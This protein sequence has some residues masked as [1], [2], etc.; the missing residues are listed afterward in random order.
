MNN[1]K[2]DA[3]RLAA[4]QMNGDVLALRI[5]DRAREAAFSRGETRTRRPSA[6]QMARELEQGQGEEGI[7]DEPVSP[8]PGWGDVGSGPR[9]SRRD[10]HPISD[11]LERTIRDKGWGTQL[12]VAAVL[13]RW[14]EI[15]G[16][17]I[18]KHCVV[19]SFDDDG[20]LTLRTSSTSWEA[21]INA[22]LATLE[23]RVVEEVGEGIVK[24]IMVIG[25]NRP[26]WKHGRLSVPGRGPRDTYD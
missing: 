6:G 17:T 8:G 13:A 18:A 12:K 4:A 7:G 16:P 26:S 14:P 19:E 15:V 11:L 3:A 25:P 24:K 20:V 10:P 5:L 9:P 21:Q 2:V 23:A 22:L 1:S